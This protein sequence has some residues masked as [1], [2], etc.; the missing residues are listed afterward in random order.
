MA[1]V[2]D[3]S[4]ETDDTEVYTDAANPDTSARDT[5]PTSYY[6][7]LPT[8]LLIRVDSVSTNVT[9]DDRPGP[10]RALDNLFQFAGRK[11]EELL[12]MI[13]VRMGAGPVATEIKLAPVLR[14]LG[15]NWSPDVAF[16][17]TTTDMNN[18]Y[19]QRLIK[20][21]DKKADKNCK[22]ILKYARYVSKTAPSREFFNRSDIC[23]DQMFPRH[24]SEHCSS[25]SLLP[26]VVSML[27]CTFGGMEQKK[28]SGPS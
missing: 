1:F 18:P 22:K 6:A 3:N 12:N 21:W 8:H 27:E 17:L 11:L 10:G 16:T 4:S 25:S 5:A 26:Q 7:N 15:S 9:E 23:A 14:C 28:R 20:G 24:D 13:A 2:V 19:R